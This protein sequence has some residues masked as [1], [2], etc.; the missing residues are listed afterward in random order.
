MALEEPG[1]D[2]VL[3]TSQGHCLFSDHLLPDPQAPGENLCL[4]LEWS[5]KSSSTSYF[6]QGKLSPP[7]TA[8]SPDYLLVC[9]A[10]EKQRLARKG[11]METRTRINA[12]NVHSLLTLG[13]STSLHSM[14]SL[15]TGHWKPFLTGI[16]S[17]QLQRNGQQKTD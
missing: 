1:E 16:N 9:L 3:S 17:Q 14:R 2:Q 5:S 6:T 15:G 13:P 10:S 11:S 7:S 12:T 8:A 4:H